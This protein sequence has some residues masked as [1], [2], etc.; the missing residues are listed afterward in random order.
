[1]AKNDIKLSLNKAFIAFSDTMRRDIIEHILMQNET[2]VNDLCELF[3]VS[4]F[5][6]MR[7]LNIL[8]DA[9]LLYRERSG[10]SKILYINREN[11]NQLATG[12]LNDMAT[13]RAKNDTR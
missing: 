2:S 9:A 3:P 8:E 7:H 5:V 13:M 10:N 4:R 12:W 1:M 11:L 6:V